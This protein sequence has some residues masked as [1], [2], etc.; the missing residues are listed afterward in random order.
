M[1]VD[2]EAEI[3]MLKKHRCWHFSSVAEG[4]VE[5]FLRSKKGIACKVLVPSNKEH[6]F[7]NVVR[8][9]Q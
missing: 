3:T 1:L 5:E 8:K 6:S 9:H 7:E 2:R 4:N